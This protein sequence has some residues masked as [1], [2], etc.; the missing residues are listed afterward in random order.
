MKGKEIA[1]RLT[2]LEDGL[3]KVKGDLANLQSQANDLIFEVKKVASDTHA[4]R[5][6]MRESLKAMI[7]VF[8]QELRRE[9]AETLERLR[10]VEDQG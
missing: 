6:G 1:S 9:R 2:A 7:G 10:I 3:D 4:V 5:D 8:L